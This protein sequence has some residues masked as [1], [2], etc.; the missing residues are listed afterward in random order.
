MNTK[1]I[2]CLLCI[3]FS[4]GNIQA[5]LLKNLGQTI[6]D[7]AK[8]YNES[9]N[10]INESNRKRADTYEAEQRESYQRMKD[11]GLNIDPDKMAK[12]DKNRVYGNSLERANSWEES[13]NE[14]DLTRSYK[15]IKSTYIDPHMER[16]K[17]EELERQQAEK[18]AWQRLY[19]QQI[20]AEREAIRE[21][22]E[23][24]RIQSNQNV[25]QTSAKV[26]QVWVDHGALIFSAD[27]RSGTLGMKIHVKFTVNGML[28]KQGI[29]VVWF[30]FSNGS[31]LNSTGTFRT[32]DGQFAVQGYYSPPY[33]TCLYNDFVIFV[34]Y[35]EFPYLG[36]GSHPLQFSVGIFDSSNRQIAASDPFFFALNY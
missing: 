31:K 4:C 16:L 13:K 28:N 17:Q 25:I 26:E 33:Q 34:P 3:I 1:F 19:E 6:H 24:L 9:M 12:D 27:G 36:Q 30:C 18:D 29:C 32:G 10:K 23:M 14:K 7:A 21:R 5:Q 35:R 11:Q 20:E 8:A 2:I 22:E 15:D